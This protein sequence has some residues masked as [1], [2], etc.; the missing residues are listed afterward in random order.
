MLFL[1]FDFLLLQYDNIS[2]CP[3]PHHKKFGKKKPATEMILFPKFC[4]HMTGNLAFFFWGGGV[5]IKINY[6]ATKSNKPRCKHMKII[7]INKYS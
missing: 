2:D 1:L 5:Q 3:K 6:K 7:T 4:L